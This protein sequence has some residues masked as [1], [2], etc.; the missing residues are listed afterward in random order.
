M[1]HPRRR[2]GGGR[3]HGGRERIPGDLMIHPVCV[4]A[5][6]VLIVNDHILKS[7]QP[8]FV[9]GKLSDVS[10]VL[11]LPVLATSTAEVLAWLLGRWHL[12]RRPVFWACC[13]SVAIGFTAAKGLTP[14]GSAYGDVLGVVRWTVL[15]PVRFAESLPLGQ[16]QGVAVAHDPTDIAVV[17]MAIIGWLAVCRLTSPADQPGRP[18]K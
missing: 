13:A 17:P 14:V 1:T 10:G 7:L 12:A 9:T 2:G 8:G 6:V 15:A 11:L 16:P 18:C 4:V 5:I 3:R